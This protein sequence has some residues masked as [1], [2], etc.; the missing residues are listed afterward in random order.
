MDFGKL[1]LSAQ[2]DAIIRWVETNKPDGERI[3]C[4]PLAEALA[5]SRSRAFSK[6]IPLR[7][8]FLWYVDRR[9]PG[10]LDCV[11]ARTRYIDDYVNARVAD[12]MEQLVNLGAG[13]D[14]RP[15][16]IDRLKEKV[17][18][19]EVDHPVTQKWKMRNVER[20]LGT[21]QENVRYVPVDFNREDFRQALLE[22]GY[23]EQ[24][25]SLFIW[26]GVSQYIRADT[27]DDT[28][29]FVA[30]NS[31]PGSSIIFT[32]VLKSV[33]DGTSTDENAEKVRKAY[34]SVVNSTIERLRFGIE[35]GAIV[36]FLSVRGF[37]WIVDISGDFY[38][39]EYFKGPN[40][41]R[42]G[43]RLCRIAYATVNV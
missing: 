40:R 38:E 35:E 42:K 10:F 39:A 23:D 18:I 25:K 34:N 33:V 19:F 3:C 8:A 1:S 24:K 26:E 5:G 7:K 31:G 43:C 12:G 29:A 30:K 13:F 36:E 27:V 9:H 22:G 20:A 17:T 15:Y 2:I 37:H 6:L 16:R 32:Y 14:S 41:N 28:L 4:D 11:P 21:L